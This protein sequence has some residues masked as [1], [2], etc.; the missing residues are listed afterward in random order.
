MFDLFDKYQALVRK[1]VRQKTGCSNSDLEQEIFI[2]LWQKQNQYIEQGKEKS[3]VCIIAN[4][5]CLDFFKSKAYQQQQK[6]IELSD[7]IF[8]DNKTPEIIFAEKE[9]QKIILAA[10]NSLPHKLRQVI[11][12]QEYE[13]MSLD[14][15]ANKLNIPLGT[16]KSRIF[17][18]RKILSDRLFFLKPKMNN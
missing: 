3:W 16:V 8:D 4:N 17:N 7:V 5:M 15:I 12:M 13:D 1:I 14:E 18:A 2:R 6:S 9:R 11:I 10:V